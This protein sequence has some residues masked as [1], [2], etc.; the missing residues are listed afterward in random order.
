MMKISKETFIS[1]FDWQRA[2]PMI[3]DEE[4]V[5]DFQAIINSVKTSSVEVQVGVP[6]Y[7]FFTKVGNEYRLKY[8]DNLEKAHETICNKLIYSIEDNGGIPVFVLK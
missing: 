3:A 8:A 5:E 6:I 4:I 2:N 1:Y 7:K